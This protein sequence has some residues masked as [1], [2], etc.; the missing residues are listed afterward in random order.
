MTGKQFD[1][2]EKIQNENILIKGVSDFG[3]IDDQI[4]ALLSYKESGQVTSTQGLNLL[5]NELGK[6]RGIQS[7]NNTLIKLYSPFIKN[8]DQRNLIKNSTS[9]DL[10]PKD[11]M[12]IIVLEMG[13][14]KLADANQRNQI[15][16]VN[17]RI[18]I[19]S[20]QLK[21]VQD[22]IDNYS[23]MLQFAEGDENRARISRGLEEATNSKKNIEYK[24]Q[25]SLAMY[26]F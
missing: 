1:R 5:T 22:K 10:K 16:M 15:D 17:K 9:G 6:L 12:D 19:Y 20:N 3:S 8:E 25:Q 24:I 23:G 13:F 14:E 21:T 7:K 26:S 11:I 2:A 18:D 4:Q